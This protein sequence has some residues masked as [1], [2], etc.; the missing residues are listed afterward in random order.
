MSFC[1]HPEAYDEFLSA[2]SWY[3]DQEWG[4]GDEFVAEIQRAIAD[5]AS[6]PLRFQVSGGQE[7]IYRVKRFPHAIFY[8]Y[9]A[10]I[11]SILIT[12][13]FNQ[14]VGPQVG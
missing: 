3:D 11:D 2:A 1:F 13:V 14:N 9:D 8:R 6:D 4:L 5:I 7:R 10:L 12:T